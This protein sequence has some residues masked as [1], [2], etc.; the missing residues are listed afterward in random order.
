MI[1]EVETPVQDEASWEY[2]NLFP[3]YTENVEWVKWHQLMPTENF[4]WKF[5]T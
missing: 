1:A 2:S 4:I 3:V 5:F